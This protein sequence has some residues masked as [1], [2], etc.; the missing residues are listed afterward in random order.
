MYQQHGLS[1]RLSG[2]ASPYCEA[3]YTTVRDR[4]ALRP[5]ELRTWT[6]RRNFALLDTLL[7]QKNV[8]PTDYYPAGSKR[9]YQ[10]DLRTWVQKGTPNLLRESDL[11]LPFDWQLTPRAKPIDPTWLEPGNNLPPLPTF[12]IGSQVFDLSGR[13]KRPEFT[14]LQS[15]NLSIPPVGEQLFDLPA[16]LPRAIQTYLSGL[17]LQSNNPFAQTD[18]PLPGRPSRLDP[19]WVEPGNNFPPTPPSGN[20]F[21]LYDWP[22]PGT[23]PRIDRTWTEAGNT[24]PPVQVSFAP[25]N[26][27]DWPLPKQPTRLE[28]T[29]IQAG[30]SPPV[31]TSLPFDWQVTYRQGTSALTWLSTNAAYIL[32]APTAPY[33]PSL[34][35]Q[36]NWPLPGRYSRPDLTWIEGGNNFPPKPSAVQLIPFD[37]GVTYR[38]GTAQTWTDNLAFLDPPAG[39]TVVVNPP[40]FSLPWKYPGYSRDHPTNTVAL[41]NAPR[42]QL[43]SS[44]WET[45]PGPYRTEQTWIQNLAPYLPPGGV[46]R[47]LLLTFDWQ[48]TPGITYSDKTW[49]QGITAPQ[50]LPTI[51]L[52]LLPYL[53]KNPTSPY[54]Q[55]Q[56]YNFFNIETA[57]AGVQK[58]ISQTQWPLPLIGVSRDYTWTQNLA[59]L[60]NQSS[61]A[62]S[63]SWDLVKGPSRIDQ[64]WIQDDTAT[65]FLAGFR[66]FVQSDWPN[67]RQ[68]SRLQQT[69]IPSTSNINLLQ[70]LGLIQRTYDYPNPKAYIR[71][72]S[73]NDIQGNKT[74]LI[75]PASVGISPHFLPFFGTTGQLKAF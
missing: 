66:P 12:P 56:T 23:Y 15:L 62:L 11:A 28:Q 36:Y 24:F 37:W 9:S 18:W 5:T 63:F 8:Y 19:T 33:S 51:P 29:W 26:Q 22:N 21:N 70:P 34:L 40:Y 25:S 38:L 73:T 52:P 35:N 1:P 20:P 46:I 44:S 72:I 30:V 2:S 68:Y 3:Y 64:T 58:P 13:S 65:L 48:L 67:F 4:D 57:T 16:R 43:L 74:I 71:A 61:Y 42:T 39:P 47:F 17:Q 54:R 32:A 69:I 55:E 49:V 45:I 14:W 10:N 53:V 7:P 60:Y 31:Q 27:F 50:I 41:F 75:P 6:Q 59:P